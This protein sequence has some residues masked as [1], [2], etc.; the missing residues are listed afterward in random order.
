MTDSNMIP[1]DHPGSF[2]K[3]ELEERG[4]LQRD[5]SFVLGVPEQAVNL[6]IAGKRG[7]SAE[8]A[9]A[10]GKAFDV[11]AEFF[12]NLQ[13]LYDLSRAGE[14]DPSIER[15]AQLQGTVP[16]REMIKRG[17]LE[18]GST[19][20]IELQVRD[21]FEE[22]ARIRF[23]AKKTDYD[24]VPAAQL[25]WLFRVRQIARGM[26]VEK[27]SEGRLRAA[28]EKLR[29]LLAAPEETR[30]VPRVLSEAGVRFV[31][32]EKLAGSKIDGVCTWLDDNSPVIGL[33][34]RYDRIDNF[35]FVLRHE[36]EH[37]LKRHGLTKAIIDSDLEG[38]NADPEKAENE[39][40]R[41]ANAAA[42]EFCVPAA[43]M[44][45]FYARKY[46][47]FSERDVVGFA[48]VLH[49]HPGLVVG[50]L[51]HR[52]GKFAFLRKYLERVSSHV[53]PGAV[54]DGWGEGVPS[55]R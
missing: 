14:P 23:A 40:E 37:V 1:V 51:Q 15:R 6:I 38:D 32:V 12:A 42:S 35:W 54:V 7:I 18:D 17:W 10:L 21:L 2:I 34:L 36:I 52:T 13:K 29:N 4:W 53:V 43:K 33:S 5:L 20:A 27:Y 3:E 47:Y 45:S 16:L 9:K 8:M 22:G 11:P 55:S 31:I 50:Q 44:Q 19:E 41:I 48:K 26:T 39:E 28:L 25:V 46:P 30:H 49:V 24:D